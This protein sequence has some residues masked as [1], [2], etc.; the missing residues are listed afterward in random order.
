VLLYRWPRCSNFALQ[1]PNNE[2]IGKV[3]FRCGLGKKV[4]GCVKSLLSALRAK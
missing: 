3:L 1:N 4:C 2:A